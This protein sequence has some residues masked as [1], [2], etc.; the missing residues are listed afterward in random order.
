MA[1]KGKHE[2]KFSA[3]DMTH[4]TPVAFGVMTGYE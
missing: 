2:N 3:L 4:I 1:K